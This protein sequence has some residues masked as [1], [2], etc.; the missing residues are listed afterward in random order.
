MSMAADRERMIRYLLRGG[1]VTRDEEAGGRWVRA[2][3]SG[4]RSWPA[5]TGDRLVKR[6][7]IYLRQA[8]ELIGGPRTFWMVKRP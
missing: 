8:Y 7:C 2:S 6:G 5:R 4:G 3:R 1:A